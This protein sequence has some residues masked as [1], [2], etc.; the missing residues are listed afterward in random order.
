MASRNAVCRLNP[1]RSLCPWQ[2]SLQLLARGVRKLRN[3]VLALGLYFR[4]RVGANAF[5]RPSHVM[6]VAKVMDGRQQGD[7]ALGRATLSHLFVC[8]SLRHRILRVLE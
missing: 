2:N 5:A 4:M 1:R 3:V 7:R 8:S 6:V